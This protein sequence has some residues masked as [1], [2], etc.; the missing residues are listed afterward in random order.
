MTDG[1]DK[2]DRIYRQGHEFPE[3]VYRV[4]HADADSEKRDGTANNASTRKRRR[5]PPAPTLPEEEDLTLHDNVHLSPE[6]ADM[7]RGETPPQDA[8]Q[9]EPAP[10]PPPPEPEHAE[11]P[12]ESTEAN[13]DRPPAI[14]HIDL[15]A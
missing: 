15:I 12:T 11:Q 4:H 2:S 1:V 13:D 10:S 9:E 7:L 6:A 3:S 14:D 5:S 8:G